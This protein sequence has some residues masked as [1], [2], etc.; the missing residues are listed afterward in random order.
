MPDSV[1]WIERS[2]SRSRL[3][4]TL[5]AAPIDVGPI[6]REHLFAKVPTVVMTSATLATGGGKPRSISS[7]RGSG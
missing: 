2:F 4:I 3:R 6:L 1:Y 5:S 7:S